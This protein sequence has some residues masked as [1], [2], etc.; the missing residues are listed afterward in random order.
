MP[1]EDLKRVFDAPGA[2][3]LVQAGNLRSSLLMLEMAKERNQLGRILIAT[4]SPTGTGVMP[5]GMM[6]T[7]ILSL[8]GPE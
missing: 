5:L 3:Q 7:T 2:L 1:D 8:P 4:D 6:K